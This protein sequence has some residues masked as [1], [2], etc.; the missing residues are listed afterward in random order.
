MSLI[1][2]IPSWVKRGPRALVVAAAD[3]PE[4]LRKRAD[5]VCTGDATAG[6]DQDTINS[7][8]ASADTVLLCPGTYWVSGSITLGTGQALI[9]SGR[10]TVIRVRNSHNADLNVIS[11]SSVNRVLIRDLMVD[12][13]KD[14]QTAG[15]MHGIYFSSTTY[16]KV[17]NCWIQ[18]LR[19]D[20]IYATN[21][22]G[23]ISNNHIST[24]SW[25]VYVY[26]ATEMGIVNND[27]RDGGG[28]GVSMCERVLIESNRIRWGTGN[29]IYIDQNLP[30][31]YQGVLVVGN[32]VFRCSGSG[33]Y[34][35]RGR[36]CVVDGN[37][38]AHN[39]Y[40][41]IVLHRSSYCSVVGNTLQ[42][43]SYSS[44]AG[45][46]EIFLTDDGSNF[47]TY[48][49]V[50]GNTILCEATNRAAYGIRENASGDDYNVITSN[51]AQGARTANISTQGVNSVV[52]NN[53]S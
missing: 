53:I 29:G 24:T 50:S 46:N 33:I 4:T 34:I 20:G 51:I 21:S 40:H 49:V 30:A 11:A 18:A 27:I 31:P 52:A 38:V 32:L 10:S 9:G 26:N 17:V 2:G 48:N 5:Y 15:T 41:G 37:L 12:G 44:D 13:N 25:A 42:S 14:N 19:N 35:T 1:R 7:A 39:D 6:G 3:T 36:H 45:Y 22:D 43:N 47:S 28:I 8:L 23:L 16:L